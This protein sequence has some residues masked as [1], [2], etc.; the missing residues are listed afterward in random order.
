VD[1]VRLRQ[2]RDFPDPAVECFKL[3]HFLSNQPVAE[4]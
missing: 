3:A 4:K 2:R 1:V